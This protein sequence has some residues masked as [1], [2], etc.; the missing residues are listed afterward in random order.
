MLLKNGQLVTGCQFTNNLL[1]GVKEELQVTPVLTG[2]SFAD[3][4]IDY[5]DKTITRVEQNGSGQ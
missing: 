5:Y 1:Y 3:N 4:Y 2:C